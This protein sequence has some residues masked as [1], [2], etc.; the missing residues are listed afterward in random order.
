MLLPKQ[1]KWYPNLNMKSPMCSKII[2]SPSPKNMAT[3]FQARRS[4]VAVPNH[5][6]TKVGGQF[7]LMPTAIGSA[8]AQ[9]EG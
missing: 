3:K 5:C 1:Y 6:Y 4:S 8:A 9:N 2:I 7:S